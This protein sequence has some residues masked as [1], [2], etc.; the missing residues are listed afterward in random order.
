M[1]NLDRFNEAFAHMEHCVM[2]RRLAKFSLRHRFWL[3]A[4]DSPL[5]YGGEVAMLDLELAARVC[6]I[7]AGELDRRLPRVLTRG[8]G[9]WERLAYVCRVWRRD[10]AR[11]YAAFTAYLL[12]HGCP[13][14]TWQ[15]NVIE[16]P[17]PAGEKPRESGALPGVFGLV[18]GL[19]RCGLD[20]DK[21][22]CYSPGEAEWYLA[23]VFTH[24]GVDVG[25]KTAEDEAMEEYLRARKRKKE[26]PAASKV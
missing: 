13:P 21:V 9:R 26:E 8:P 15:E 3:E 7:P 22:W 17:Q 4:M 24:R 19:V 18:S 11:E 23:G 14:D 10:A 1:K 6:A 5:M 25:L 12:D 20:P 2:G 16:D